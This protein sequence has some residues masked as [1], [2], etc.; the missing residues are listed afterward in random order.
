MK[1]G[2]NILTH[3]IEG[4]T[5]T[6]VLNRYVDNAVEA[7]KLGYHSVWTTEHHFQS[8]PDYRPFGLTKA[9]YPHIDYDLAPDPMMLLAF[10][11]AKTTTLNVGT[12][13]S[14]LHWDHP[15]RTVETAAMLD[16]LSGGRL[17][18]GVGRG[19]G[20]RE[21]DIFGVP[22]TP[23][24]NAARYHE[25]LEIIRRAWTGEF[26][27]FD[28][29]YY[30]TPRLAITPKPDRQPCPVIVGSSSHDSAIWAAE[31]DLPYATIT[32]PLVDF[33]HYRQKRQ[34]Y[35]QAGRKAGHA[36]ERHLCPHF[37]FMYCG[38]TDAEAA[39]VVMTYMSQFQYIN[40]HHYE[41]R[42]DHKQNAAVMSSHRAGARPMHVG[43]E[44]D[45]ALEQIKI[46]S[47]QVID[48]HIVGSPETCR[49]RV[50]MFLDDAGANMIVMNMQF[51]GMPQ[52]LHA[53]SMRR[54]AQE[55]MPAFA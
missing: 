54:F 38:E 10:A 31:H 30:K 6:E 8:E 12:A 14:I 40:E 36:V 9:Q 4:E 35:L 55:V 37:L 24:G 21:A 53:A 43:A 1:F 50:R 42:R 45:A 2:M 26:F 28:G 39:E 5:S 34:A 25:A 29:T 47:Q 18:L 32:W 44:N 11:A 52:H 33:D 22:Q 46:S 49:E 7:E 17:M 41:I 16:T 48:M 51:G 23:E 3:K 15:I 13:V 19:L 20:F 27:E